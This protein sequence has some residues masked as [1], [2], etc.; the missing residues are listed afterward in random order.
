M[1]IVEVNKERYLFNRLC[2]QFNDFESKENI[3]QRRV[4]AMQLTKMVFLRVNIEHVLFEE[5]M[6]IWPEMR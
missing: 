2:V 4:D 5:V 6:K 1:F 3:E